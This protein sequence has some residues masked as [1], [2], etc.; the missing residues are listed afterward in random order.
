LLCQLQLS[1]CSC[2]AFFVGGG[3]GGDVPDDMYI[4]A[5]APW[6]AVFSKLLAEHDAMHELLC[7]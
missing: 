5:P 2:K 3:S 6:P 4:G 7:E 1:H